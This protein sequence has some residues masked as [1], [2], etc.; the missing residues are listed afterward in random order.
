MSGA[1]IHQLG[2]YDVAVITFVL[3]SSFKLVQYLL[4]KPTSCLIALK[5]PPN[6]NILFGRS[7][8]I[9][10]SFDRSAIY[11]QWANEYGA[12]YKV[13]TALGGTRII[14]CD[15]KAAAHIY[16]KDTFTYVGLPVLKRFTKKFVSCP[17]Q[18]WTIIIMMLVR[19]D[20]VAV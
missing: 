7:A 5:G 6:T 8:E 19:T 12:V 18:M 13:P 16:A 15:P 4:R 2:A 9:L 14:I 20:Y 10:K 3:I 11:Q 17:T 1:A